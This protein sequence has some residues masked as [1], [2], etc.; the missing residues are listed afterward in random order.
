MA[1]RIRMSENRS[2]D[3]AV[4]RRQVLRQRRGRCGVSADLTE[5]PRAGQDS[6]G[7]DLLPRSQTLR[8]RPQGCGGLLHVVAGSETGRRPSVS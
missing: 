1:V 5:G 7:P 8:L 3:T 6:G 2:S 4:G